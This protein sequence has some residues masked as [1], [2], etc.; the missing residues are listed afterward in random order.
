MVEPVSRS[1][2]P[3]ERIAEARS[4]ARAAAAWRRNEELGVELVE[5]R[6]RREQAL[7][8]AVWLLAVPVSFLCFAVALHVLDD[9]VREVWP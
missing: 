6:I 9:L 8:V 2:H 1:D 7:R 4:F 3:A 5:A